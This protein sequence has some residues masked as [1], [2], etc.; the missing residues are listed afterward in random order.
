[1]IVFEIYGYFDVKKVFFF[2]FIGGVIKEV[3]DGMKICGDINICFMG[4]FGVVK[5]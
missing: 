3:G 1:M 5:L 2:F 4:D